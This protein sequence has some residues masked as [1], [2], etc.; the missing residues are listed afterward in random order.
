MK[1][2]RTMFTVCAAVAL[3]MLAATA[4]SAYDATASTWLNVRDGPGPTYGVV[5]TL[6]PDEDVYVE[7]C[8]RTAGAG[9]TIPG[10]TAG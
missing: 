5:D 8:R 2:I 3:G 1:P 10:P 4:A 6:H 9:S 7:E